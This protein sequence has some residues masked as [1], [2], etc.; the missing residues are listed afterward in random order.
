MNAQWSPVLA[1][2]VEPTPPP[3]R[4]RRSGQ[5]IAIVVT[6][7][8]GTI[9]AW[10]EGAYSLFGY[11]EAEMLG[12]ALDDFADQDGARDIPVDQIANTVQ[13]R[14]FR[15][16]TGRRL[17]CSLHISSP[18]KP[19]DG[20]E[21]QAWFIF[22][23]T[24]LC[25]RVLQMQQELAEERQRREIALRADASKDFCLALISHELKQPL[26][27]MLMSIERMLESTCV[28]QAP[29]LAEDLR[30]MRGATRR[31]ARIVAD[32][33][34]LSRARTGKIHLATELVEIG[35]L[36]GHLASA[37]G[38][39]AP[40]KGIHV[41]RDGATQ[42]WCKAD[43]VRLEQIFSNLLDNAIKFSHHGG[44]I[45]IHVEPR[46]GFAKVSVSDHGA[47]ISSEF[48]SQVFNMFGQE[49]RSSTFATG[50]LGIGLTLA[51]E[52]ARLHDGRI[53][54][55]SE[56]PGLGS[57]FTVWLPLAGA[58]RRRPLANSEWI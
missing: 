30:A 55:A 46:D 2:T 18:A 12:R 14:W 48:L 27:T 36:I 4:A 42:L 28:K 39:T 37:V 21:R 17:F 16:K 57:Q 50:G 10:N 52:L 5:P 56:G 33:L 40:D 22:D 13:S 8:D 25:D 1:K 19:A 31:Q 47:G 15:H 6:D 7:R 58:L 26:T 9:V 32:L 20:D 41:T 53:T 23:M 3:V 45:D 35:D 24:A 44:R 54:V 38:V 51:Q 49:P 34:E 11:R 29:T 43:P